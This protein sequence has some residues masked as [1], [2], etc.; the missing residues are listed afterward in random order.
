MC[1]RDSAIPVNAGIYAVKAYIAETGNYAGLASD[2]VVFTIN[3]AAEPT[4]AGEE[5]SYAYSAGSDGKTISV[6][7][8]GKLPT[9][10][11]TTAYALTIRITSSF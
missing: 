5:R 4:I 2:P 1:I 11:G 6:D 8:A 7:I 3:K 9:D 10:R